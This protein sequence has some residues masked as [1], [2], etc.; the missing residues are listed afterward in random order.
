MIDLKNERDR[1]KLRPKSELV[2]ILE[3]L[4][5]SWYAVEM[6]KVKSLWKYGWHIKDIAKTVKRDQ[7]EVAML[8]MHLARQGRIRRRRM[9]VLGN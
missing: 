7:D 3:D 6:N 9:G 2:I 5:F 4:D 1:M 8:I